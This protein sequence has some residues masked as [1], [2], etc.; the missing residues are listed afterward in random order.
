MLEPVER[1]DVYLLIKVE[2]KAAV[3]AKTRYVLEC[4]IISKGEYIQMRK[5]NEEYVT[6]VAY[7][8]ETV[9]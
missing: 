1:D 7:S 2:L 5:N 8:T 6:F 3:P 4:H 9:K